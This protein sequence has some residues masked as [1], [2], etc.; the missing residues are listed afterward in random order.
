M[1]NTT[2]STSSGG[3]GFLGLLTIVF[4]TLK[5][6]GYITWS[7]LWVVSPLWIGLLISLV[8]FVI[9]LIIMGLATRNRGW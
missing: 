4:I 5:L 6:T 8:F 1:S 3:I 7:W 2:T 9:A